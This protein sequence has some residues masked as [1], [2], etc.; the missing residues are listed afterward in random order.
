MT[1]R[2]RAKTVTASM[3]SQIEARPGVRSVAADPPEAGLLLRVPAFR[4]LWCAHLI[5]MF[6]D[7]MYNVSLP[8]LA[9][10]HTHSGMAPALT[11]A[12]GSFSFLVVGPIAG[13]YADR[14][15]RKRT[16]IGADLLRAA[17]LVIV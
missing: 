4:W 3:S 9:W 11:L 5:S 14:W 7:G 12:A 13:V 2:T 1:A 17:T 6:G 10:Q 8:W 15:D 16:L